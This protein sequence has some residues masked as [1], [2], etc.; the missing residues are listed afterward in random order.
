[1]GEE[2]WRPKTGDGV[3]GEG[4]WRRKGHAANDIFALLFIIIQEYIYVRV[5]LYNAI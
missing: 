4:D 3:G 2:E 1:M 5:Y